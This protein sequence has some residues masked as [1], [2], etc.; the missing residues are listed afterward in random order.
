MQNEVFKKNYYAIVL[1][2][3]AKKDGIINAP[4]ARKENSIIER[5]VHK[6]GSIAITKYRVIKEFNNMSLLDISLKTGRTHQIRVHLSYIGHPIIGDTLY[7]CS[8]DKITRQALHAYKV[9]LQHP[10]TK[11]IMN[12]EA[13]MPGDMRYNSNINYL[14]LYACVYYVYAQLSESIKK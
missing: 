8:S 13:P 6:D 12:F 7:G 11:K 5:C 1:G 9:C 10:I 2:I 4:I 14:P 3:L